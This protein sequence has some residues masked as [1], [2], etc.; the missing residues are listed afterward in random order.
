MLKFGKRKQISSG[1]AV[2]AKWRCR[3]TDSP[4]DYYI[5]YNLLGRMVPAFWNSEE[6]AIEYLKHN[7]YHKDREETLNTFEL[8]PMEQCVYSS[9]LDSACL[10]GNGRRASA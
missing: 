4:G 10:L 2:V 6:E 9:M 1:G 7:Y 5:T 3:E 8:I